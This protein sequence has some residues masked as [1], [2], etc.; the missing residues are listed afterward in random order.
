M[1]NIKVKK[2]S[3][4]ASLGLCFI[5][6]VLNVSSCKS[7]YTYTGKYKSLSIKMTDTMEKKTSVDALILPYRARLDSVM[8]ETSG[9]LAV[10]LTKDKPE[11]TLGNFMSDAILAEYIALNGTDADF[12]IVNYGGIRLPSLPPGRIETGKMYELMPFDNKVVCLEL[13]AAQVQQLFDA[14]ANS[15]GWPIAGA[16]YRIENSKATQITIQGSA[17]STNKTYKAVMSD[18][19]AGGGDKMDFLALI[20]PSGKDL[21]MRDALIHYLQSH[22]SKQAPYSSRIEGRVK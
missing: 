11:C 6:L 3:I 1:E 22:S 19:I 15:G 14:M 17:L 7:T 10:E 9:Y 21:L 13:N 2:V 4:L 16:T 20:K 12:A 18:Y 8:H 5:A